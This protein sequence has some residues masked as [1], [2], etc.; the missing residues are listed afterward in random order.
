MNQAE[1]IYRAA[2]PAE[3]FYRYREIAGF[4]NPVRAMYQTIRELVENALDATDVHGIPPDVKITIRK[5]DETQEFY[6][7]T[8]E[9]NGIGIPPN[10]VPNAFGKVLFSSKYAMRQSRGMYGLGVKMVVLYAQMTTGRPVEVITSKANFKR[11]Y[12]FKLR[13]DVNKNEPVIHRSR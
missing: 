13:I 9:D 12:Y 8:V 4:A 3:F 11:I 7:I 5:A 6:Q 2:S 10:I 1:E